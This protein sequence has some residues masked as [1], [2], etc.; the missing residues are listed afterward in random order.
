[1]KTNDIGDGKPWNPME[2]QDKTLDGGGVE[3]LKKLENNRVHL[4]S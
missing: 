2:D 1:M 4:N 3:K